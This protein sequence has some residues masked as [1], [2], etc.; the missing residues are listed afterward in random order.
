MRPRKTEKSG[1]DD[2]FRSRLDQIIDRRH[3]RA[4]LA[5]EIDWDW[6]DD[7]SAERF[8]DDGRPGAESRFMIGVL[9]LKHIDELSDEGVFER[10]VERAMPESW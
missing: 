4:R 1:T 7:E 6:L 5:D 3:E 2:L 8:A 9:L 10:W